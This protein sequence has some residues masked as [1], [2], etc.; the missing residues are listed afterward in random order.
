MGKARAG[1]R[2][3]AWPQHARVPP[4]PAPL[5]AAALAFAAGD[6][7]AENA[8]R[9]RAGIAEAAAA[10]ARLLLTPE[11]SLSGYPGAAR[12]DLAGLDWCA[13]GDA[14]D[15]LALAAERA[16]ILLVLGTVG[17]VD[18]GCA[19][20]LLACGAVAPRRYRKQ[21]LTP[22]D[23]AHFAAG[24]EAV[25]V[26][27]AGWRLGLAICYDLRF[28]DV[29]LALAAEGADA[30][31]VASHLAGPEPDPGTKGGVI[32]ARC[33]ARAAET[34]T[35]LLFANT[36]APDRYLD[37]GCW[38]A[39]GVRIATRA[40]GLLPAELRHRGGLDPWYAGLRATALE[41][42][43]QRRASSAASNE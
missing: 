3:A 13:L 17:R 7:V 33:A 1:L 22:L 38:D 15:A 29:W 11:C 37:S 2:A 30:F 40:E 39:R 23:R 42:W 35:P 19:N 41:R 31:L 20:E 24:R 10:G 43:A 25:V 18:A 28:P 9:I 34:A 36:A 12:P 16:G 32:P 21:C 5:R 26:E 6:D 14:E 27:H 8:A 4:Y